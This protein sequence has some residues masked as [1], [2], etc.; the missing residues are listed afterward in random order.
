MKPLSI[1]YHYSTLTHRK[2]ISIV[3]RSTGLILLLFLLAGISSTLAQSPNDPNLPG[4]IWYYNKANDS[5]SGLFKTIFSNQRK[6]FLPMEKNMAKICSIIIAV[7]DLLPPRGFNVK[8]YVSSGSNE[9][10][11]HHYPVSLMDV[12]FCN[13][14]LYT[15]KQTHQIKQSGEWGT[16]ILVFVNDPA[17]LLQEDY[18]IDNNCDSLGIP[19]FYYRPQM[20]RDKK[21]YWVIKPMKVIT[22]IRVIKKKGVSLYIPLT[23]KEY[24]EYKLKLTQKGLRDNKNQLALREKM[25]RNANTSSDK[26]YWKDAI[27]YANKW[28]KDDLTAI[29]EYQNA[30]K[31]W[32]NSRLT[33]PAYTS[34]YYNLENNKSAIDLVAPDYKGATELV[35]LNMAYFNKSLPKGTPQLILI[36]IQN[37]SRFTPPDI[38]QKVNAWF[39]QIDYQKL[40]AMI[41]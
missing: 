11:F 13:Y 39:S 6:Y 40:Q 30:L 29:G 3:I 25:F 4:K 28:V 22:S 27:N 9:Q 24:L 1:K 35:R 5:W 21:G 18:T 2:S 7:P 19:Y 37:D 20:E 26:G 15:D 32:A 34:I 8:P 41:K 33:E 16:G 31:T 36:G 14:P 23:K 38:N 17:R 12:T 10:S